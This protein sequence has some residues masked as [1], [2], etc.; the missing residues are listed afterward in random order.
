MPEPILI[1]I[2]AALAAKAATGIYDLVK[3]KFS[4]DPAAIAEL[5]AASTDQPETITA[6]AERLEVAGKEDPEFAAALREQYQQ[7]A[8][9]INQFSGTARNVVQARDI[10][11][12]ISFS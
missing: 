3:K 5:E 1:S 12:G 6:I 11:G 9:V 2:A 7:E 10:Q 4:K 8:E